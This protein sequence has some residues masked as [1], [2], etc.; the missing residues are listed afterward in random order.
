MAN[1]IY[2]VP[3]PSP[4]RSPFNLSYEYKTTTEMG[5]LIPVLV[6]ELMPSSVVSVDWTSIVRMMPL[7]SP[8]LHNIRL[9]FDL[10]F[11]PYRNLWDNP[12][13]ADDNFEDFITG[14]EDGTL[15][16]TFPSWN[17]A[18]KT[19]NSLWDYLTFPVGI[20]PTDRRPS[21]LPA[22]AY[23]WIFNE[24]YRAQDI[25][26]ELTID[27]TGGV[28]TTDYA[29]Q[30][31]RWP[32][33]YYTAALLDQQRGTAPSLPVT[34]ASVWDA[35]SFAAAAGTHALGMAG[36]GVDAIY[37]NNATAKTELNNVFNDNTLSATSVNIAAFRLAT[38]QQRFL[39]R[40]NLVGTRYTEFLRGHFGLSPADGVLQ[41]PI[42]IGSITTPI[43]ISEVLQTSESGTTPQ[44]TLAGHGINVDSNHVGKFRAKEWG[45]LMGIASIM[46]E[47][48][49]QQGVDREWIKD[50]RY[51][52]YSPEF[53]QLS[54]QAIEEVELKASATGANNTTLFGYIG[55][56]DQYRSSHS[57]VTGYL[58]S[59]STPDFSHWTLARN[60]TSRPALNT[61]FITMKGTY[62]G[63]PSMKR[64]FAVQNEYS[65][66][67]QCG[68]NIRAIL[69]LP[70]TARPGGTL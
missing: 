5:L 48:N 33:D 22:R 60:F 32:H 49:Y 23:A 45:V 43:R 40:N 34:G 2:S 4:G 51:D 69:P 19:V 17:P 53:A 10:F 9:H 26:T 35:S 6:K 25:D 31:R 70:F 65:F 14:G 15:T 24:W 11:A 8:V 38:A 59:G 42:H 64:I 66:I 41:R 18:T 21:A 68:N 54:D 7:V 28:D 16:P 29:V 63:D 56:W 39:E 36:T 55:A 62:A 58:R 27:L 30:S 37:V 67:L 3:I 20:D 12:A 44:G 57:K 61:A 46:P 50:T 1:Q 47:A 13:D 52:F